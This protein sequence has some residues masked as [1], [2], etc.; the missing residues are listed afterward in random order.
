MFLSRNGI[1]PS[2]RMPQKTSLP[3]VLLLGDVAIRA[4]RTE[5]TVALLLVQLLR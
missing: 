3:T 1:W 4:D 5:N 2:V